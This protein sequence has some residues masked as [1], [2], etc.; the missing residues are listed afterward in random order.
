MSRNSRARSEQVKREGGENTLGHMH[1]P[2]LAMSLES[3]RTTGP[4]A[5][6]MQVKKRNFPSLYKT[7]TRT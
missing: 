1:N 6:P 2:K 4:P 3:L 7:M 5:R